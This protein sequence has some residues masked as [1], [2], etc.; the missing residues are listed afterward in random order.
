GN[1]L[2]TPNLPSDQDFRPK[3][4][5]KAYQATE[6]NGLVYVYMG[7]RKT[8]PPL[9]KLEAI[10]CPPDETNL[11]LLQRECNWLQALE[12]DIDTSHFSF[13]HTGKIAADD[14]D[15]D[16]LERFQLTN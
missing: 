5:A 8:A 9:P 11:S 13:L 16:H 3:V 14:V 15:P 4:K 1:C 2:D 12:G 10:L 7:E 6:R